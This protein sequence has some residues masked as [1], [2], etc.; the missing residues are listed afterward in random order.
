[1]K[2]TLTLLVLLLSTIAYSQTP[3]TD[4][5][6]KSAI[7]D[8]LSFDPFNGNCVES[9]YGPM[10]DWDV[11][12]VTNMEGAFRGYENFNVNIK[13]WDVSNVTN[14]RTMFESAS[15]FNR[16]LNNWDVSNVTDMNR[17]FR[18]S[19]Y[20]RYIGDW[21]VSNVANMY[22]MFEG[23][24]T[25]LGFIF[26]PCPQG[27][28]SWDV[29]N[30]TTMGTMFQ[31][32]SCNE[33][34]GN[35]DVSSVTNMNRMF[36]QAT[37]FNQD[38]GDWDVRNVTDMKFM[39]SSTEA[40]NQDLGGWSV[41][42]LLDANGMLLGSAISTENYDNLL[43][44]WASQ[45]LGNNIDLTV[46]AQYC[47]GAS[48]REI[49]TD[50]FNWNINDQGLLDSTCVLTSINDI[51]NNAISVYPNP[52][53]DVLHIDSNVSNVSIYNLVGAKVIDID[54]S[55]SIDISNLVNGTY[56]AVITDGI[57]TS[58]SKFIKQ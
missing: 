33:D 4:D 54:E 6:F 24:P 11:S 36:N 44:G 43:I 22:G 53:L 41:E 31:Y 23:R 9:E 46:S 16:D 26:N 29:S 5:N 37:S 51:Q 47:N 20:T 57:N 7:S 38:I 18:R 17:M 52:V 34:V 30:V 28:N 49:M 25:T 55:N 40:F 2:H 42:Y 8:C 58:T 1:M 10:F 39:L 3:I 19:G 13:N 14:M 32:S 48:A 27:I 21:D 15:N 12:N 35:W 56:V 50:L 45:E